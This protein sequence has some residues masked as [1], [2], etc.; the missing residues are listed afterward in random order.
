MAQ[1]PSHG[2]RT[3][4]DL[5]AWQEAM[6]LA[7]QVYHV[8]EG[9]PKRETFGL[10]AQMRRAA[11]S[12]PSNIAEGFGRAKTLDFRRFLSIARGSLFE[13][14][15]QAELARRLAWLQGDACAA[16]RDQSQRVDAILSGLIRSVGRRKT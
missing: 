10:T 16:L 9:F 15:T 6:A 14:Q 5:V 4:R 7:E 8:T 3:Y 11:V 2:V 13:V 1:D 12:V